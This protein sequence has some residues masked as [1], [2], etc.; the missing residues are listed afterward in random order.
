MADTY[1]P[2]FPRDQWPQRSYFCPGIRS[3]GT[4]TR[5]R[6][7][8]QRASRIVAQLLRDNKATEIEEDDFT[9]AVL[10]VVLEM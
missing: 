5:V 8:A 3:V 10:D 4:E 2:S 6:F 9:A 7:A 1:D